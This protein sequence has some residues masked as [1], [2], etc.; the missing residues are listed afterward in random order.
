MSP[1]NNSDTMDVRIA[2]MTC[3]S[4]SLLLE[5]K[6]MALKGVQKAEVNWRTGAARLTVERGSTLGAD[7]IATVIRGAGYRMAD[8]AAPA[9]AAGAAWSH[10]LGVGAAFVAVFAFGRLLQLFDIVSFAPSAAGALTIGGVLLIG[11]V[12][13]GSS[14]LAVTGGLLLAVAAKHNESH[15]AETRWQKFQPLLH[16]NVGRLVSYFVLGGAVGLIGQTITLSPAVNGVL[17]ILVAFVM[18][19]L[20]LSILGILPRGL[21]PLRPPRALSRRIAGLSENGHPAAPFALGALTFFLP[22]GFTQSLQLAALASGNPST[23]AVIMGAFALGTL[24]ALL[25]ISALSASLTGQA[26]RWFLR[27]SGAAVVLLAVLN[28]RSGIALAGI[29]LPGPAPAQQGIAPAPADGVQEVAMTVTPYGYE[30]AALTVR[31]GVPVRWVVDGTQAGGCTAGIVVPSLGINS[32][33]A[34]GENVFEFT[35]DRPGTIPFTCSMG[36]VSGSFTVI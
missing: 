6:L 11:L 28:L 2:G 10:W 33:L 15:R 25:G 27:F 24:P 34:R 20:G 17:N 16:F 22:C 7:S 30:P 36:M 1:K 18:L 26:S 21:I 29:P 35:P 13:G 4:C 5:R 31:A 14:C 12:A 19:Y 23:G 3:E 32:I 9:A 8:D